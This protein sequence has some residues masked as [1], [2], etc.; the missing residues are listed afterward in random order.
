[1]L[2][3]VS[4]GGEK[5]N[6]YTSV[7]EQMRK[8][9]LCFLKPSSI[10]DSLSD[11]MLRSQVVSF[12]LTGNPLT[13]LNIVSHEVIRPVIRNPSNRESWSGPTSQE[14]LANLDNYLSEL[15]VATGQVKGRTLLPLPEQDAL[16]ADSKSMD[17][18]ERIHRLETRVVRCTNLI[19]TVLKSSSDE[20]LR[21]G[22]HPGPLAELKF[23]KSKATDL[24]ALHAQ[25]TSPEMD[26]FMTALTEV[27]SPFAQEFG[28]IL[29]RVKVAADEATENSKL[30]ESLRPNFIR[31]AEELDYDNI[32]NLFVPIMHTMLLIWKYSNT[33]NTRSHLTTLIQECCNELIRQSQKNLSG[34]SIFRY[35]EDEN[36]SEAVHIIKKVV[37]VCEKFKATFDK[38]RRR[39]SVLLKDNRS[40][41]ASRDTLFVRLDGFLERCQDMLE[42]TSMVQEF[43][44]LERIFVGGTKGQSLT[45]T[46]RQI[47]SE[48][49][50]CVELFQSLPYDIM[51]ITQTAF[52]DDFYQFRCQIKDLE[53]RV[54]SVIVSAFDDAATTDS[55][56]KLFE[57]FDGL[58]ERPI[59][60]DEVDKRRASFIE[61]YG[62]DLMKVQEIFHKLSSDPRIDANLPP[63]AGALSW[64][65][66]LI[67]RVNAP[68]EKL[69][70]FGLPEDRE[71]TFE[72]HKVRHA[73]IRQLEAYE[74]AKMEEWKNEIDQT[75]DAKLSL[76]LL[77]REE[78]KEEDK[79]AARAKLSAKRGTHHHSESKES[80]VFDMKDNLDSLDVDGASGTGASAN[81]E[82]SSAS[83]GKYRGVDFIGA[84]CLKVNFDPALVRLLRE[85]KYFLLL[86]LEVPSTALDIYEQANTFRTQIGNL[87]LIVSMYNEMMSTLL[88]VEQPLVEKDI[89][90]LDTELEK[91][92]EAL[93]W[94]SESVGGFIHETSKSVTDVYNRVQVMRNNLKKVES[95][96]S[97]YAEHPLAERKSKAVSP[98]D[99]DEHLRRLATTRHAELKEHNATVATLLVETAEALRVDQSSHT[100]EQYVEFV[101]DAVRAGLSRTIVNS[102]KFLCQQIDPQYTSREENVPLLEIKVGLYNN[103]VLFNA[104]DNSG[105]SMLTDPSGP[106]RNFQRPMKTRRDVWQIMNDWVGGFFEIGAIMRRHNS[107]DYVSELK[108]DEQILRCISRMNALLDDNY[109]QCETYRQEY[110]HYQF[111]WASDRAQEFDAF[112]ERARGTAR[113]QRQAE[114]TDSKTDSKHN[115]N[116]SG[117]ATDSHADQDSEILP[118]ELF[119]EK[120]CYYLDLQHKVANK[121][122]TTEQGWLR[123]NAQPIKQALGTWINRWI[124]TYTS[125]LYNEV[126]RKL[127]GLEAMMGEVE[128][129][130]S[131]PVPKGDSD[132]LKTVLGF[133]HAVKSS[134]KQTIAAFQPLRET[135]NMLKKYGRPLDEYEMKLLSDAPMKWDSTV[136][137]VYK[138]K[139]QVNTLQNE[140]VDKI[141]EKIDEFEVDL[142]DFRKAFKENAPFKYDMTVD[143]AYNS[144][145]EQ[146]QIINDIERKA[147]KLNDLERVFELT[148]SKHRQIAVARRENTLLKQVWD[149]VGMVRSQFDDWQRTLWDKIDTESL[150]DATKKLQKQLKEIN[151][152]ARSWG[153]FVG[154]QDE[155]KNLLTVLPLVT[156]LHSPAMRD[157][158]WRALMKSTGKHF[159][160]G[161]DFC[162]KNLLDLELHRFVADVEEIVEL[163]TKE[164]KIA[165]QLE[166]IEAVWTDMK[167]D[168]GQHKETDIALINA[169]DELMT[170]LEE[171]MATLQGI[172]GM[173]KYVEHFADTVNKW[174]N[175]L[176]TAESV[177]MDWLDVQ[178]R[179]SS[180]ESI[181]LGS[182]DIRQQLPEDSKRFEEIHAKWLVLMTEVQENPNAIEA[183]SHKGRSELL[184]TMKLGLEQCEKSLNQ[185]LETKRKAFPRFYF[186]SNAALLDILSNGYDPQAVQAHLG[187]CFDNIAKLEFRKDEKTEE[188]TK[189]A[190]GMYSKDG[191]EYVPFHE[192][193]HCK[194]AVEDWLNALVKM[195]RA[196]LLDILGRAKFTAD[197]WEI[198]KARKDWLFDYPAQVA[199]T[200]SQI[201]WTEEVEA[202][203]EAFEDGNEQ[204]MKEY[205]KVILARLESLIRLV[206]GKLNKRDR[207][208]IIT[209][210]T[211]DVHNRDVVQSLIDDKVQDSNSFAWQRQMRYRWESDERD[212]SVIVADAIF[213]YSYEYIGNT[214]RLV[215]TPLTDRCYITLTQALRLI[216]GG[217]PAGPAGTGKTETTKDLGRA[218]GLPVYVFNCSGKFNPSIQAISLNVL[219]VVIVCM[220]PSLS[221]SVCHSVSLTFCPSVSLSHPF[222]FPSSSPPLP[223]LRA[224]ECTI[225]GSGI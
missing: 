176:G 207:T 42:F 126:T 66:G 26:S 24:T 21:S 14:V 87:Q 154:L 142:R 78:L 95:L 163:A 117:N 195:M 34:E 62:E 224:N 102:V 174:Q 103:E 147:E 82:S 161:P 215:I 47:H 96:M 119:E 189:T 221:L 169:S 113:R 114:S 60:K 205:L 210:I 194:G 170:A 165:T 208:K 172:Q 166:K 81:S 91:G 99:F 28:A 8:K 183:C 54:A 187:D 212:C 88:P 27:K 44:K 127:N 180:L 3:F 204:A 1:V 135:A 141:K 59:V 111:L 222:L 74:Q 49:A 122:S 61:A 104:E 75:S 149:V 76:P 12:E 206:L 85:V 197:H 45:A 130:L 18:K 11:E 137:M 109:K 71:E 146:H 202:T 55:R 116:E 192:D 179:W 89:Q 201:I 178:H 152:E 214:G 164:S 84:T 7:P 107:N 211:V 168:F 23:W 157:R 110:M 171:N 53:R 98:P 10:N 128:Q 30:L 92:M 160:M 25:L 70:I 216:M 131:K 105:N 181:F 31:L 37:S 65:R 100:W 185:Y 120:I 112:L 6:V 203:F 52:D 90:G 124:H 17:E 121:E 43:N 79:A 138:V 39:A 35:I 118:L 73:I 97:K 196:T 217:A 155:V 182:Q 63:I 4:A 139:E 129:G 20:L 150:V 115:E 140:E 133:I 56:F 151:K 40:W 156:L 50:Q 225:Y 16:A 148:V 198:E 19:Q 101:E 193:F 158:H 220:F 188:F 209:L 80:S 145:H 33:Y 29:E 51:D 5:V 190:V 175:N 67:D 93:C 199:L 86:G 219:P 58:L 22:D 13:D 32:E 68:L 186:L 94:K 184:E 46:T 48:F 15:Y 106:N 125:Y 173:G 69:A 77:R 159:V 153:V 9:G 200:A 223:L 64:C 191:G 41:D 83:A 134:E 144:I 2:V 143:Q 132:T 123:I 36:V 213:K 177:L 108:G 218:L 72:V 136:A 38:Y 162:L 167:L 57:T